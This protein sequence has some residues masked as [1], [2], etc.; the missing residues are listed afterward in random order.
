MINDTDHHS[1]TETR[2]PEMSWEN[3]ER[4]DW[5]LWLLATLL[6]FVLGAGLLS[7]MFPSAFWLGGGLEA[8][9]PERAFFGF[10]VLLALVL[11]YLL[12]KQAKVRQLRRELYEAQANLAKVEREAAIQSFETLPGMNQFRDAMAM[13]Y[14]RASTS[15][16]HLAVVL[17]TVPGAAL[18]GLGRMA[19]LLRSL[20]RQGETLYRISDMAVGI[21]MPGMKLSE[22]ASF[23]AQVE[24]LSG[25][26]KKEIEMNITAYPEDASSL[27]ALEGNLRRHNGID[28]DP[29]QSPLAL[30]RP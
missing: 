2:S 14:R 10:C 20:L 26:S 15:G 25:F 5:Q 23:A 17:L 16:A 4:M 12:Q 27:N 21:L 1:L 8:A 18:E 28:V 22:A 13:E 24:S 9:G 7:F 11:V 19:R 6:I 30:Q 3:L 29:L